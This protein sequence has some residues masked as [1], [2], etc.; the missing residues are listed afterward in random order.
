MCAAGFA[1]WSGYGQTWLTWWLGDTADVF[2]VTPLLLVWR[3]TGPEVMA[4]NR[5]RDS[6]RSRIEKKSLD[7]L[8]PLGIPPRSGWRRRFVLAC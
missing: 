2:V 6:K 3:A 8:N 1:P 7:A 4:S 5:P